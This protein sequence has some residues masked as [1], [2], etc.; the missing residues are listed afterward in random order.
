MEIDN[1]KRINEHMSNERTF[2][3]WVRTGIG[4]MV[5]GFVIVNFHCLSISFRQV[6]FRILIFQKMALP[7]LLGLVWYLQ[8]RL[9]FFYPITNTNKRISCFK[10]A[11]IYIQHYY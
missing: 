8:V 3:S 1:K 2:L 6:F 4:I 5:F 11:N 9:P 10:K 7:F